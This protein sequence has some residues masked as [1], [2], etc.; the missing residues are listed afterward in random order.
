MHPTKI[1]KPRKPVATLGNK[2]YFKVSPN[3]LSPCEHCGNPVLELTGKTGKLYAVEVYAIPDV[4]M[5]YAK[6]DFHSYYC[7]HVFGKPVSESTRIAR[8]NRARVRAAAITSCAKGEGENKPEEEQ[9]PERPANVKTYYC[10]V[11]GSDIWEAKDDERPLRNA[12]DNLPHTCSYETVDEVRN[13]R[14]KG[15]KM[16][17]KVPFAEISMRMSQALNDLAD[18]KLDEDSLRAYVKRLDWRL[19]HGMP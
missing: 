12:A 2:W 3:L 9:H 14:V 13:S 15:T 19:Y 7:S 16:A 17:N 5:V 6:S 4:G 1:K 11:C 18:G 8:S 10:P